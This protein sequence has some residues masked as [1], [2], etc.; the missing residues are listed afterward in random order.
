MTH[1]KKLVPET[2]KLVPE[3]QNKNQCYC[4]PHNKAA[5]WTFPRFCMPFVHNME[6]GVTTFM[7]SIRNFKGP[8]TPGE[9]FFDVFRLFFDLFDFAPVSLN[10]NRA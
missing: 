3:T 2:C 9:I 8:F 4:C 7:Y 10:V 5:V 1:Y 6:M